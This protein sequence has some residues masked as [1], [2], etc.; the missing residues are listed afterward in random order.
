[1]ITIQAKREKE[2]CT[3]KGINII[4]SGYFD[5]NGVVTLNVTAKNSNIFKKRIV[6]STLKIVYQGKT[7]YQLTTG[8]FSVAGLF[9]GTFSKR[10]TV[11]M[12]KDGNLPINDLDI[13][14]I[15][16][17]NEPI[18]LLDK[19]IANLAIDIRKMKVLT[20]PNYDAQ[21]S[22]NTQ[23]KDAIDRLAFL[24]SN[25]MEKINELA[26]LGKY[27]ALSIEITNTVY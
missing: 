18:T 23:Y 27:A 20:N 2:E 10:A 12:I 7:M 16:E 9:L 3:E 5:T 17:N 13:E 4:S 14:P 21:S 8:I 22:L 24:K 6:S 25:R 15:K 1:M 26:L 19:Q 11:S